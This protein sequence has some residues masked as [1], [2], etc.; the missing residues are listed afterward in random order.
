MAEG[1]GRS[2]IAGRG[3]TGRGR[4]ENKKHRYK[5]LTPIMEDTCGTSDMELIIN[6]HCLDEYGGQLDDLLRHHDM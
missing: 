1:E 4:T 2:G 6:R 5:G 3:R